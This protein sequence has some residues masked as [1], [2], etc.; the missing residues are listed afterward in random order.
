MYISNYRIV[1]FKSIYTFSSR[2]SNLLV[3]SYSYY[4]QLAFNKFFAKL[5]QFKTY[6][7]KT[8]SKIKQ[9]LFL[10]SYKYFKTQ[11]EQN[12]VS[13]FHYVHEELQD[14]NNATLRMISE[15]YEEARECWLPTLKGILSFLIGIRTSNFI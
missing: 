11:F 1:Y 15:I 8:V 7:I 6:F 10:Y 9:T 3:Y 2:W 4:I 5:H 12:I 14:F 13:L